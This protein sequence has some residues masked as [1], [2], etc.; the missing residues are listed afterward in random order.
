VHLGETVRTHPF[1]ELGRALADPL[2]EL[3]RL[4]RCRVTGREVAIDP[5][6][7]RVLTQISAAFER[8]LQLISGYRAPHTLDTQPS[9]QH[10][11]G[12]AA[13]IRIRGVSL[14]ALR[15]LAI[16]LGARG[17]GLYPEKGFV[18]VDVRDKARYFWDYT[19]AQGETQYRPAP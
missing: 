12:R 19:A 1:D 5:T 15:R 11:L 16:E 8:P 13:D 2:A 4:M 9:S 10:A 14:P 18:H 3:R 17:V 7:V 6:L